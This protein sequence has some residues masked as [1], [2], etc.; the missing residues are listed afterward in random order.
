M[1]NWSGGGCNAAGRTTCRS[2][3][4]LLLDADVVAVAVQI[5]C[6]CN[7]GAGH[8]ERGRGGIC[9]CAGRGVDVHLPNISKIDHSLIFITKF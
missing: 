5:I 8:G 4:S 3:A 9:G 6:G 7:G 2:F 1:F